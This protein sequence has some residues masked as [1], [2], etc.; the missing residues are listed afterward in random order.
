MGLKLRAVASRAL[1]GAPRFHR[2]RRVEISEV[3]RYSSVTTVRSGIQAEI[4]SVG[5]RTP[6]RLK[7]KP[8]CPA[9]AAGSGG[10]AG[11]G[12]TWS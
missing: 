3:A 8:N 2:S 5:M 4:A 12:A 10:A 9:G 6:E 11:G 1:N 7:V